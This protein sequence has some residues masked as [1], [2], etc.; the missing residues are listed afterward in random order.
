MNAPLDAT[1]STVTEERD[2]EPGLA[3]EPFTPAGVIAFGAASFGRLWF[4]QS[5]VAFGAAAAFLWFFTAAWFP[6]VEQ[7]IQQLPASGSI[8]RGLLEWPGTPELRLAENRFLS[9]TVDLKHGGAFRSSSHLQIEFGS[10]TL[11]VYSLAGYLDVAYPADYVMAFNRSELEPL[12][13][14]WSPWLAVGAASVLFGGLLVTWMCLS[15]L[16]VIPVFLTGFFMNRALGILGSL[17]VAGAA[18][19]PG[20]VLLIL[21]VIGYKTGLVDVLRF[22]AVF[23]AHFLIT[24]IY[25]FMVPAFAPVLS[26]VGPANNPFKAVD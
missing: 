8:S 11:R 9:L 12:W 24:W 17:K 7:G 4:V 21:G 13:G 6:V 14:A 25:L 20:A 5:L 1:N 26:G 22:G 16:Y 23:V 3:W 19:M 10:Q 2:D 18:Q 15:V